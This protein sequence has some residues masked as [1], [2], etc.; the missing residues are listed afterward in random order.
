MH[1][2]SFQRRGMTLVELLVVVTII[3]LLVIT[4]VPN[5]ASTQ[6]NRQ[7]REAARTVSSF[8]AKAHAR[9]IGRTAWSGFMLVPLASGTAVVDMHLADSPDPYRGDNTAS[10]L[11]IVTPTS[12]TTRTGTNQTIGTGTNVV[13]SNGTDLIRF[14]GRGPFYIVTS[15]S[16][17]FVNFSLRGDAGQTLDNTPWPAAGVPYPF[18]IFP[19]PTTAGSPVTLAANRAIDLRWSGFGSPSGYT[20]FVSGT[21]TIVFDGTG[22]L[23]QMVRGGN[24]TA[25]NGPVFLL[26]G[27]LDQAGTTAN[28]QDPLSSWIGIDPNTGVVRSAGCVPNAETFDAS[29]AWIRQA[30]LAGGQ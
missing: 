4:V 19:K 13:S 24:R 26:V 27:R 10:T 14:G 21:V 23:R 20:A 12:A 7:A 2:E 5:V 9:A 11:V 18:E 28:F 16:N 29:Q 17:R 3:G 6:E 15:V 1:A 22:R 25:L 8:I 30:L